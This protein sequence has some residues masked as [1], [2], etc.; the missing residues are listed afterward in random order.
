MLTSTLEKTEV[1]R[2]SQQGVTMVRLAM[3]ALKYARRKRDSKFLSRFH[4]LD[5]T[6]VYYTTVKSLFIE[7]I[8]NVSSMKLCEKLWKQ[9][10]TESLNCNLCLLSGSSCWTL[11]WLTLVGLM[12]EGK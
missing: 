10:P 12:E 5:M 4:R 2:I 6:W 8:K 1:V 3:G 11:P 9:S 7:I